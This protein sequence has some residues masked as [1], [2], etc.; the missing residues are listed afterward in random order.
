MLVKES[1]PN[2]KLNDRIE[3]EIVKSKDKLAKR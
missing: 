2:A 3:I 1:H